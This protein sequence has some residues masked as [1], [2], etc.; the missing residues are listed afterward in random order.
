[1][2]TTALNVVDRATLIYNV[3]VAVL[4][5][6]LHNGIPHWQLWLLANL[7]MIAVVFL[8]ARVVGRCENTLVQL[9]RHAYPMVLFF[10]A[11]EQTGH[12]N[13]GL[14][15]DLLDPEFQHFEDLAFGAQPAVLLCQ[16]FPQRWL[17]EYMQFAYFSYYLLFLCLGGFLF[18][19]RDRRA[20]LDYLLA[21]CG[22][23]YVCYI[24]FILLPVQ[25]AAYYGLPTPTGGGPFS[26]FMGLLYEH[27]EIEGAAFPSS[28]VAIA[29]V[30]LYYTW[31][32]ARRAVW[33][34]GPL[35]VSLIIATVFCRYHY[36]IDVL[37]G[38][39]TAA[40]LIPLW[41]RFNPDLH[42][43]PR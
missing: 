11:Y 8:M 39:V 18:L 7:L 2:N 40:V 38:I 5:L 6:A 24:I 25:G 31:R 23:M 14:F 15:P 13:R 1:M 9:V 37:A 27:C 10:L 41:R 32:Y 12:I 4:I 36:A 3:L 16:M 17:A 30:V 34:I 29:S 43:P 33:V 28:H 35:V 21:L 19:C 20:F 22:T 42:Q 26:A